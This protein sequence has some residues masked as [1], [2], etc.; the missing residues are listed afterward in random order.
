MKEIGKAIGE[1]TDHEL[2]TFSKDIMHDAWSSTRDA[3]DTQQSH[4]QMEVVRE[5]CEI[6]EIETRGFFIGLDTKKKIPKNPWWEEPLQGKQWFGE[7][8][9]AG[10]WLRLT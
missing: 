8:G 9:C 4:T 3:V 2:G 10:L 7:T 1:M 6:F 5:I